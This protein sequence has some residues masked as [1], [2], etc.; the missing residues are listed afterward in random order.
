M[1]DICKFRD[2]QELHGIF[3]TDGGALTVGENH[4]KKI[5]VVMEN[6]EM[7]TVAWFYIEYDD[8]R[9]DQKYNSKI[10]EGVTI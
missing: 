1:S 6:G 5:I 10:V 2:G 7:A 9:K 8:G 4:C 3:W